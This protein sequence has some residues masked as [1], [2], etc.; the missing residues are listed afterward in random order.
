MI[1]KKTITH[2]TIK[3]GLPN[4][5]TIKV[6]VKVCPDCHSHLFRYDERHKEMYCKLCGLVIT[7]PYSTDFIRPDLKT[8]TIIINIPETVEIS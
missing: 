8:L 2:F 7:A 1:Q 4:M 3:L 6:P 5:K